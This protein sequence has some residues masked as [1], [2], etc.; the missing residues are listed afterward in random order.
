[1]PSEGAMYTQT[2]TLSIMVL[3]AAGCRASSAELG[4]DDSIIV[5]ESNEE[6]EDAA[7][8]VD[9]EDSDSQDG[10]DSEGDDGLP[11]DD[12][13]EDNLPDDDDRPEDDEDSWDDDD[14][15]PDEDDEEESWYEGDVEITF[16]GSGDLFCSGEVWFYIGDSKFYGEAECELQ[17]G[18]GAGELLELIFDGDPGGRG[19]EG[20]VSS[21]WA[22]P[23]GDGMS[24]GDFEA[25][26]RGRTLTVE[27]D[28]DIP[29]PE[30][31]GRVDVEGV[32][33]AQR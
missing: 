5:D 4:S 9:D 23:E 3:L 10:D 30:G 16:D 8:D 20:T 24:D 33:E 15:L 28:T 19:Y 22:P 14:D 13:D 21:D 2:Y 1:M 27:W 25:E 18:P 12:A 32:A 31:A 17:A 6:S 11:D 7:D 29:L 26:T